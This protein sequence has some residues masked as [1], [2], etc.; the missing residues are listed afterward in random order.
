[1]VPIRIGVS[2]FAF[3]R[4]F[5]FDWQF[6][7]WQFFFWLAVP[8][9]IVFNIVYDLIFIEAS[10]L[11]CRPNCC[12]KYNISGGWRLRAYEV[13]RIVLASCDLLVI[14]GPVLTTFDF[15]YPDRRPTR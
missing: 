1:M 5:E 10:D 11:R 13:I 6:F 12:Q 7:E 3:P 15:V 4:P 8:L 2:C 9:F 14:V